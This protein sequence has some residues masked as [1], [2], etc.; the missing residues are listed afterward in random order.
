[1]SLT[2]RRRQ[3]VLDFQQVAAGRTPVDDLAQTVPGCRALAAS[4]GDR[5]PRQ[6]SLWYHFGVIHP[7]EA[8]G[9]ALN[10]KDKEAERLAAEIAAITG[11]SKTRAVK[12]ALRE[13]KDRLGLRVAR[14]D[15]VRELV[16]FLEEEVWP[17]IPRAALDRKVTR[18]E[19]EA[20]LG[21][22][23]HGV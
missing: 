4:S 17:Q 6:R 11:E 12:I 7:K 18:R 1:M 15:H 9:M 13:R 16:S 22:G 21:Y 8:P 5:T 23:P 2:L 14:R 20:I 3:I 19:R 10:I